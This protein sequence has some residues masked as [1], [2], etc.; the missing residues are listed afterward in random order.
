MA[1][2][3]GV[4]LLSGRSTDGWVEYFDWFDDWWQEP[5]VPRHGR[6]EP[7]PDPGHGLRPRPGW[8][9]AHLI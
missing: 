3:I 4:Q 7:S 6:V 5:V 2:E 8:F 1:H 9:E